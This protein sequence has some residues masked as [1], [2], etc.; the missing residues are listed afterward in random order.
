MKQVNLITGYQI[1]TTPQNFLHWGNAISYEKRI[2]QN[3][4][5]I[6]LID[7]KCNLYLSITF[8]GKKVDRTF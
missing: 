8:V 2:F 4:N 6:P 5:N 7:Y 3:G 1:E